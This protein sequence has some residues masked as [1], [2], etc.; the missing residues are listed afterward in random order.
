MAVPTVVC[1]AK[2]LLFGLISE[3]KGSCPPILQHSPSDTPSAHFRPSLPSF[4]AGIRAPTEQLDVFTHTII[5]DE[6]QIPIQDLQCCFCPISLAGKSPSFSQ[7]L[8]ELCSQHSLL[9]SPCPNLDFGGYQVYTMFARADLPWRN[10][11]L[12]LWS[13]HL[14]YHIF[15]FNSS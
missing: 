8:Q 1:P 2:M 10:V 6:V 12:S 7:T 4:P 3:C 5:T 15:L 11:K 14:S 9:T 13:P